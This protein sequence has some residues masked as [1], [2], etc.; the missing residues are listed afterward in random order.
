[1][2]QNSSEQNDDLAH[3]ESIMSSTY[4]LETSPVTTA[5]LSLSRMAGLAGLAFAIVVA[6]VNLFV[7]SMTPPA[8][9][10]TGSEVTAFVTENKTAL[11]FA[12]GT[13]PVAAIALFVFLAGVYPRLSATSGKAAFWMRM[14]IG[15][16]V[17]VEVIFLTRTLFEAALVAN[18]ETLASEPALVETL[19]KLQGVAMIF[20]GLGLALTLT[21]LS[22]AARLGGMIPAWHQVLGFGAAIAF[23]IPAI[24]SVAS[25]EGSPVGMLGFPAFVAWLTWLA[26]TSVR[27]LRTDDE[28]A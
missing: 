15:G 25:L 23:V 2:E 22:R 14:G 24:A 21:G 12:I 13:V 18:V 8:M 7:G 9:D 4:A 5:R 11:S 10:A 27:L 19:W 28:I 20:S 16:G 1:M 6:F 26:L 17:L 3:Q